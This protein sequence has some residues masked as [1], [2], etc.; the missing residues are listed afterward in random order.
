MKCTFQIMCYSVEPP[1]LSYY[2]FGGALEAP[3]EPGAAFGGALEAPT[4]PGAAFGAALEAPTEP[5]AAF[6]AAIE[7]P[8]LLEPSGV[9][10]FD[11]N[12]LRNLAIFMAITGFWFLPIWVLILTQ[13]LW[14]LDDIFA[15]FLTFFH[16]FKLMANQANIMANLVIGIV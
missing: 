1:I 16:T 5:G 6:G 15:N 12:I 13:F 3:T 4:E 2:T 7:A 8:H 11:P 9:Q 14:I 10:K